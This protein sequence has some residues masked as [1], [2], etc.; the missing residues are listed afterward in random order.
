[1]IGIREIHLATGHAGAI[2]IFLDL[3]YRIEMCEG[4]PKV[5]ILLRQRLAERWAA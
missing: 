2:R 4:Y 3:G 5:R 1:M